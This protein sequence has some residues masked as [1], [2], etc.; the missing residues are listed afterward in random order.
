MKN[1]T[2]VFEVHNM[3]E[4]IAPTKLPFIF[5]PLVQGTGA[6]TRARTENLGLGLYIASTIAKAHAGTLGAESSL[7]KGTT[8]KARLPR[9]P[10]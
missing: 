3:G 4:P 10:H 2:P 7:D 1:A 6:E 5:Q 9:A 8:F